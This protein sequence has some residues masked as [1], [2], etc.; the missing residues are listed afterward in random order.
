MKYEHENIVVTEPSPGCHVIT[1]HN[2]TSRFVPSVGHI[3]PS[4]ECVIP[5]EVPSDLLRAIADDKDAS[6]KAEKEKAEAPKPE[7][8]PVQ[9]PFKGHASQVTSAQEQGTLAPR[10]EPVTKPH[11]PPV[12]PPTK[13]EFGAKKKGAR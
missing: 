9:T 5:A 12:I 1:G 4:F 11:V 3:V 13:K 8:Q 2:P 6:A 10:S 7:V